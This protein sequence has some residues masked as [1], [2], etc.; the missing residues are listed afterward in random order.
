MAIKMEIDKKVEKQVTKAEARK[1]ARKVL[2][3]KAKKKDLSKEEKELYET[4]RTYIEQ[5]DDRELANDVEVYQ[6]TTQKLKKVSDDAD[7]DALIEE[8]EEEYPETVNKKVSMSELEKA[9]DENTLDMVKRHGFT[10]AV[11]TTE[12]VKSKA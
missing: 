2:K 12:Y 9:W 10:V 1:A 6:R 8:L 7:M 3:L 4:V 11:D 5:T